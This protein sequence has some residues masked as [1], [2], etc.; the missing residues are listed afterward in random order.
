ML[1]GWLL[2][3]SDGDVV[4]VREV[5][6]QARLAVLAVGVRGT[7]VGDLR[8]LAH[9]VTDLAGVVTGQEQASLKRRQT[10]VPEGPAQ[11]RLGVH[12]LV[13]V[14]QHVSELPDQPRE[15]A[16]VAA[17]L[18]RD[19]T[20]DDALDHG[21]PEVLREVAD[22]HPR[23]DEAPRVLDLVD[24]VAGVGGGELRAHVQTV[25]D[26]DADRVDLAGVLGAVPLDDLGH[27]RHHLLLDAVPERR[28]AGE[29]EVVRHVVV[30]QPVGA[31]RAAPRVLAEQGNVA[32]RRQRVDHVALQRRARHHDGDALVQGGLERLDEVVV[33]L[34]HQRLP[35][36]GG[37]AVVEDDA[38]HGDRVLV[39]R[40]GVDGGRDP[41]ED[42]ELGLGR[43]GQLVGQVVTEHVGGVRGTV[44]LG[45]LVLAGE[46]VELHGDLS[47]Y[48]MGVIVPVPM[49][50]TPSGVV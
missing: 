12:V 47:S 10:L 19:V 33:T 20:A 7:Q 30:V 26:D 16:D 41:R 48:E 1:L 28:V 31:R 32:E 34:A 35:P 25:G 36:G 46:G 44:G 27:Q 43:G 8:H 9:R 17:L 22:E 39:D 2:L 4:V 50:S 21:P 37:Q 38:D 49:W 40:V 14:G 11:Q 42:A 45:L 5:V 3:G 6:H 24:E 18:R 13:A 29:L 23:L 15:G